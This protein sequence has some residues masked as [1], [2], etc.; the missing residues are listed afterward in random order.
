MQDFFLKKTDSDHGKDSSTVYNSEKMQHQ[1][2]RSAIKGSNRSSSSRTAKS[3]TF[4][5]SANKFHRDVNEAIKNL[6]EDNK[7]VKKKGKSLIDFRLP[8]GVLPETGDEIVYKREITYKPT[9]LSRKNNIS[10]I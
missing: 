6:S 3:V 9:N 8:D 7:P 10:K 1:R 5:L 2:L 4:N